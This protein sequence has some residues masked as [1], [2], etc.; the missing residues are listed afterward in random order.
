MKRHFLVLVAVVIVILCVLYGKTTFG[1]AKI[2]GETC[3]EYYRGVLNDVYYHGCSDYLIKTGYGFA[4]GPVGDLVPLVKKI[5]VSNP[6]SFVN[7]GN[8]SKL[9]S[10]Y[11]TDGNA[12]YF[13]GTKIDNV[14]AKTFELFG[15]FTD[16]GKDKSNVYCPL[17]RESLDIVSGADVKTFRFICSHLYAIDAGNVY[18]VDD[19][20]P[21]FPKVIDGADPLS[22]RCGSKTFYF[23]RD[24]KNI[25]LWGNKI[26]GA[27]IGTFEFIKEDV[28]YQKDKNSVYFRGIKMEGAD[29]HT[30]HYVSPELFADKNYSYRFGKKT[31]R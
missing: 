21:S 16:C 3:E 18:Y 25:Y 24:N 1:K 27:D 31:N 11:F 20:S 30:F 4:A 19:S 9:S 22:F 5:D 6:E 7:L 8:G 26:I 29:P 2:P 15:Y 23:A 28:G 12:V 10:N 14:D 17:D 13:Y